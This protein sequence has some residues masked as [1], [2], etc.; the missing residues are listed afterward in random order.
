MI[1][2]DPAA[3]KKSPEL[4]TLR[5][6]FRDPNSLP[7]IPAH[8]GHGQRA[9]SNPSLAAGIEPMYSISDV[10]RVLNINRRTFERMRASGRVPAH[11][12]LVG[13]RSPRWTQ[14]EIRRWIA[15]GTA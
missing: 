7:I 2:R 14:A 6:E 3:H 5:T 12:L 10:C 15:E 13:R 9:E 8:E 4:T 11:S 1:R